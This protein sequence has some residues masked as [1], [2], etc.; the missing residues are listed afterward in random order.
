M[1]RWEAP[2]DVEVDKTVERAGRCMI[3]RKTISK[4]VVSPSVPTRTRINTISPRPRRPSDPEHKPKAGKKTSKSKTHATRQSGY[5][6]WFSGNALLGMLSTPEI[7]SRRSFSK[8]FSHAHPIRKPPRERTAPRTP[9]LGQG[10]IM[11]S[12][13][14]CPWPLIGVLRTSR[15]TP[16]PASS[17]LLRTVRNV[18]HQSKER[19]LLAEK[20]KG[21][22]GG[23]A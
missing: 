13:Q 9:A 17:Y 2:G 18:L 14:P 21:E 22:G 8:L 20:A 3:K 4:A 19:A 7:A 16:W 15:H 10:Y 5:K 1:A 12:W 11:A 6:A 23:E